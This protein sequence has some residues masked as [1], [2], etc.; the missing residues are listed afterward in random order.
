MSWPEGHP[1]QLVPD[2]GGQKARM[3]M[4]RMSWR[5]AGTWWG[6]SF[7]PMTKRT[8]LFGGSGFPR[9]WVPGKT[10]LM[11]EEGSASLRGGLVVNPHGYLALP[12][13]Q[14]ENF[15]KYYRV[16][17][18]SQ[19]P[20]GEKAPT[21]EERVSPMRRPDAPEGPTWYHRPDCP[22][23]NLA[24]ASIPAGALVPSRCD[25]GRSQAK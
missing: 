21:Q 15:K 19:Q 9:P 24:V 17:F 22:R 2:T 6:D 18:P 12:G 4:S 25:R 8:T 13:E 16:F 14:E 7:L 23:G 3:R 1:C 10:A 11:S 20:T 5:R